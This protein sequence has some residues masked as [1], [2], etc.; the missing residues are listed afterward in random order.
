MSDLRDALISARHTMT[1]SSND[2]GSA[3]DF[4]W[5]WGILVGW[6]EGPSDDDP[7]AG[8]ALG[9]L[10]ARFGWTE[11][12]KARLRRLHAAVADAMAVEVVR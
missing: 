10:A 6:G 12:D 8:D 7:D 1:F 11:A 9:A 2:W 3:R 4:A 5:L